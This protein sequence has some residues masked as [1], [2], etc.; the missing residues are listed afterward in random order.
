MAAVSHHSWLHAGVPCVQ[1]H[2]LSSQLPL[3]PGSVVHRTPMTY[4]AEQIICGSASCA[5]LVAAKHL[6]QHAQTEATHCAVFAVRCPTA[7]RVKVMACQLQLTAYHT[8]WSSG[9]TT[10]CHTCHTQSR[11]H[12]PCSSTVATFTASTAPTA[13]GACHAAVYTSCVILPY[14]DPNTQTHRPALLLNGP[15]KYMVTQ[16]TARQWPCKDTK[17]PIRGA[18]T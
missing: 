4:V 2:G 11:T 7:I 17:P 1:K 14:Q 3:L 6:C 8:P 12:P 16:C 10:T 5:V 15:P 13:A 9:R 18:S